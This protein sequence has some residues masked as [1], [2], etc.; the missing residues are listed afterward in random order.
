MN[1]RTPPSL[2]EDDMPE[3]TS[4][5]HESPVD[6]S[7]YMWMADELEEFD[8]QVS[9]DGRSRTVQN[10][11]SAVLFHL[12]IFD[13]FQVTASIIYKL[14]MGNIVLRYSIL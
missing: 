13:L 6:F 10:N 8:K 14:K 7:E 5:N 2:I 12:L 9:G 4:L 1:M 11:D 3:E